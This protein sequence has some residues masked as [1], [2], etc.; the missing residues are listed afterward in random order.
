[1]RSIRS[2]KRGALQTSWEMIRCVLAAAAWIETREVCKSY[3]VQI[4][5]AAYRS[6]AARH[7]RFIGR[8]KGDTEHAY[9]HLLFPSDNLWVLRPARSHAERGRLRS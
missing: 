9:S 6:L 5:T 1:M 4:Q 8:R 2:E 7:P 3:L